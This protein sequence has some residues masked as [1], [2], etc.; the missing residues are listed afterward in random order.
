MARYLLNSATTQE[1]EYRDEPR[2][3]NLRRVCRDLPVRLLRAAGNAPVRS[4]RRSA[5]CE[6][7]RGDRRGVP[8]AAVVRPQPHARLRRAGAVHRRGD[9]H[10]PLE[11]VRAQAPG[12][13]GQQGRG[14]L[15]R[16]GLGNR[17][18]RLLV[19]RAADVRRYLSNRGGVGTGGLLSLRRAGNQR[20][21]HLPHG[22]RA[23]LRTGRGAGHR[24][25]GVRRDHRPADGAAVPPERGR[26]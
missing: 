1:Q 23:W 7:H 18:G 4:G 2:M 13:E 16:L 19:Q 22:P 8:A 20:A 26:A 21:G 5:R 15:G 10:V 14:L 17:A 11:G 24:R 12:A 3:E 25:H 9:H 6:G